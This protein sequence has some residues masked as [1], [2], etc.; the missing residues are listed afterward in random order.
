MMCDPMYAL[1]LF[2]VFLGNFIPVIDFGP[3]SPDFIKSTAVDYIRLHNL[4]FL[5]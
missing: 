1:L 3:R 4:G 5:H 2:P